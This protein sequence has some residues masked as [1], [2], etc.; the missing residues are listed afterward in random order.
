MVIGA[1]GCKYRSATIDL[2]MEF[3]LSS[4]SPIS[5]RKERFCK[6]HELVNEL[7]DSARLFF[8]WDK[9]QRGIGGSAG[10]LKERSRFTLAVRSTGAHRLVVP[11]I[12]VKPLP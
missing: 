6:L 3:C 5:K 11:S 9:E 2:R 10:F 4:K 8:I 1:L 7:A 12:L